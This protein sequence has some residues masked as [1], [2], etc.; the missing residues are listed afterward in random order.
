MT[1]YHNMHGI[2]FSYWACGKF[3]YNVIINLLLHYPW[4]DN[5]GKYSAFGFFI[6]VPPIGWA[7]TATT[8]LNTS[9]Y[10]PP[11]SAIIYVPIKKY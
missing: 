9:P 6:I 1:F 3:S 2:L 8:E 4:L 10:C 7:N 5:M 11:N